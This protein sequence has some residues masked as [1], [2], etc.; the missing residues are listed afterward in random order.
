MLLACVNL[1]Q[2]GVKGGV[3]IG[4]FVIGGGLAYAELEFGSFYSDATDSDFGLKL[5]SSL[6][7]G[8]INNTEATLSLHSVN[9]HNSSATT[10]SSALFFYP[11]E[12]FSLG[13][14]A[15][16][17]FAELDSTFIGASVR[18]DFE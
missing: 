13:V 16:K 12:Y 3:E 5:A 18:F 1:I 8:F 11:T 4:D 17:T 9:L 15:G 10:L 2:H 14:V 7:Y 6:R